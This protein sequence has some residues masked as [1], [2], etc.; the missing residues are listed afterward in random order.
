MFKLRR[1]LNFVF[2]FLRFVLLFSFLFVRCNVFVAGEEVDPPI[3]IRLTWQRKD[4]ARSITITW[5]TMYENA[6]DLV[7]YDV[8]PRRGDPLQYAYS[9]TGEHHTYSGG[10]GVIHDVELAGLTPDTT[11]YFVCGGETGGFS[12]ERAFKT[13]PDY[14]SDVRF[15]AGGDCRT[16]MKYR[17]EIAKAMAKHDPAFVLLS[18]DFVEKGL[19]QKEWDSFFSHLHEYW[20]GNNNL[21]IPIIPCLGNH[22]ENATNYYEQFAL[23]GNEQWYSLDWGSNV[24]II[25]L[26]S[27]TSPSVA[28]KEWLESDLATHVNYTWKIVMFH[29]SPFSASK[30]GCWMPAQH[31][32]CPLFDKYHVDIVFCGHDHNY[33]RTK[34]INYTFS[35]TTA[36][37]SYNNGTMYVVSGGWGA[38]LYQNGSEWWTAYSRATYHFILV[39]ICRNGTLHLQA[40]NTSGTTFDET[41]IQKPLPEPRIKILSPN[42]TVGLPFNVSWEAI[43]VIDRYEIYVDNVLVASLSFTQESY[44]ITEITSGEHRI[45]IVAYDVLG[46]T[47]SDSNTFTVSEQFI[48]EYGLRIAMVIIFILAVIILLTKKSVESKFSMNFQ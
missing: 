45:E 33:E 10:S 44:E 34:A 40:K 16:G 14:S 41:Q 2:A 42:G 13:A 18:G 20:I 31:Y 6:G 29:R 8:V 3:Y 36:Q 11:Y 43:G 27:E 9:A 5:Q 35:K 46:R 37:D 4:T 47:V 24:H 28:Q 48:E 22:E 15:V 25:V 30:H 17:D 32:W 26:N 38:P 1:P 7:L 19:N 12:E 21:T 39:D 23:P